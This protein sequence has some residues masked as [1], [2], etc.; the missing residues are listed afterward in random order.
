M[1]LRIVH[2]LGDAEGI[3]QLL[4]SGRPAG[5]EAGVPLLWVFG[6]VGPRPK[7]EPLHPSMAQ[8]DLKH[9]V[10]RASFPVVDLFFGQD[11][12]RL[13][14]NMIPWRGMS[15]ASTSSP[16]NL[17][18]LVDRLNRVSG[19]A[20]M[21]LRFEGM[22]RP[23][24]RV[25]PPPL[26]DGA[27][28]ERWHA[29]T[30]YSADL[31]ASFASGALGD[32]T[33]GQMRMLGAPSTG[34]SDS[35]PSVD[36]AGAASFAE[37]FPS[38]VPWQTTPRSSHAPWPVL[39]WLLLG[40]AGAVFALS[41]A[42]DHRLGALWVAACG[43]LA[44]VSGLRA[45]ATLQKIVSVPQARARSMALG[46]VELG[47]MI[48]GSAPFPSPQSGLSCVWLRWVIEERR[49]DSRGNQHWQSVAKGEMTQLPFYLDDATGKVLV[50]PTGAE[51]E[52][53]PV[54]TSLGVDRR[55]REWLLLEGG[56]IFVYG[57][58]Q[59][60]E[61][62]EAHRS[63]L[64]ERLRASKHDGALRGRLGLPEDGELSMEQWDRVRAEVQADFDQ[65]VRADESRPDEVF[66][67]AS[68][69]VPLIISQASRQ[70]VLVKLRWRLWGGVLG[71][72]TLLIFSLLAGLHG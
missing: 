40:A 22:G 44:I 42:A 36:S 55:A 18:D 45:L 35:T 25:V 27:D 32:S 49:S 15:N 58:A 24:R 3:P 38:E 2:G 39:P 64:L 5:P 23:G 50:Q 6:D 9:L 1:D 67:G 21:D 33:P 29:F 37:G 41:K 47:G 62:G 20:W 63:V 7:N 53:D 61:Y 43:L 46:P 51:V 13:M 4:V 14:P 68:P 31:G 65:E 66:V 56:A 19:G 70:Q 57:M 52:V 59:R 48:R 34:H 16:L 17:V 28:G 11:S 54:V 30:S 72:G 10:L 60:R 26:P 69:T 12:L 8:G 71:G